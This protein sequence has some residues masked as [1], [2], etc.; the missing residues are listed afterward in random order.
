MAASLD[1]LLDV[2]ANLFK[3]CQKWNFDDP[4]VEEDTA[5]DDD[6]ESE[7]EEDVASTQDLV[8]E[9][10]RPSLR[11]RKRWDWPTYVVLRVETAQRLHE[12]SAKRYARATRHVQHDDDGRA[13]P[14]PSP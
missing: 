4:I 1:S 14:R 12:Q 8:S 13:R 3:K 9:E 2:T 11:K 6:E 7:W 10:D 5:S